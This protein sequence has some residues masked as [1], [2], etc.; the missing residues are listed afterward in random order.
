MISACQKNA[1]YNGDGIFSWTGGSILRGYSLEFPEFELSENNEHE[2]QIRSLDVGNE[3]T[4]VRLVLS[5]SNK[6]DFSQLDAKARV[7]IIDHR[8]TIIFR[9][10]SAL[11]EHFKRM[12][13]EKKVSIPNEFEWLA[14]Y[15]FENK[16]I[17][18]KTIPF[19][20][21]VL[22]ARQK[23]IM[24]RRIFPIDMRN[25]K[26]FRVFASVTGVDK[27]FIGVKAKLILGAGGK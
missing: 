14:Q 12:Q 15:K 27:E 25:S 17:E 26:S 3:N 24:Y 16:S 23:S 13:K 6:V 1:D 20:N 5:G 11:N 19:S 18:R 8:G 9:K 4:Y 22:P 7:E 21:T 2:Y 10:N